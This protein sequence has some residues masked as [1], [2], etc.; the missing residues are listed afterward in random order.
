MLQVR[1]RCRHDA[2]WGLVEDASAV[3]GKSKARLK[4]A[5]CMTDAKHQTLFNNKFE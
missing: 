5:E 1:R 2:R 4:K 3:A